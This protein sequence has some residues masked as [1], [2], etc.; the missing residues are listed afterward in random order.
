MPKKNKKCSTK[1]CRNI[2]ADGR[3]FCSTCRSWKTRQNDKVKYAYQ[4]LKGNAKRR[5]H[6]FDLTLEEF[7]E[8]CVASQYM[9]G[10]GITKNSY[11]IDRIVETKGYTKGNIQVLTNSDNLKKRYLRYDWKNKIVVIWEP[12]KFTQY[13]SK[14][15]TGGNKEFF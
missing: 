14:P 8:F 4:C 1:R 3:K 13:E 5:G 6:F 2:P 12:E 15:L 9:V 10:K 11:T 7:R